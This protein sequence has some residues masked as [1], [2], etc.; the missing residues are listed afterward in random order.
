METSVQAY[1]VGKLEHTNNLDRNGH[2][3]IMDIT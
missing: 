1:I 2:K 3:P